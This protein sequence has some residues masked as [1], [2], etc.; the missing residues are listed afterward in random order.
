[1]IKHLDR[2]DPNE[3]RE[4]ITTKNIA[5][6]DLANVLIRVNRQVI[7]VQDSQLLAQLEAATR[8]GS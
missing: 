7:V 4:S 5:C 2:P 3:V 1:M 6:S 8:P